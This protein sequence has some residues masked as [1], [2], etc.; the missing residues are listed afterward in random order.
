MSASRPLASSKRTKARKWHNCRC[1]RRGTHQQPSLIHSHVLHVHMFLR[2]PAKKRRS[3]AAGTPQGGGIV[4]EDAIFAKIMAAATRR[5]AGPID[6]LMCVLDPAIRRRVVNMASPESGKTPL[7]VVCENMSLGC[8]IRRQGGRPRRARRD[9]AAGRLDSSAACVCARAV[10]RDREAGPG[11]AAARQRRQRLHGGRP[12]S[13]LATASAKLRVADVVDAV[14]AIRAV[15][16]VPHSVIGLLECLPGEVVDV[17]LG[18]WMGEVKKDGD[19]MPV[20]AGEGGGGHHECGA[21]LFP[22]RFAS[23]SPAPEPVTL[24]VGASAFKRH[25]TPLEHGHARREVGNRRIE[26]GLQRKHGLR[27]RC[28]H[29]GRRRGVAPRSSPDAGRPRA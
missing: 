17:G 2:I 29:V 7:Y 20:G 27:R 8:A 6:G 3:S 24:R 23:S 11:R 14:S 18:G 28:G 19:Q 26:A 5:S 15:G 12:G 13:S 9:A 4:D 10:R 21:V 16:P 25:H 1:R 22:K